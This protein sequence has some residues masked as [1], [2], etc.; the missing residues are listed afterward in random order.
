MAIVKMGFSDG[1]TEI[2]RLIVM[3]DHI[4]ISDAVMRRF[5]SR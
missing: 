5:G 4:G 3:M 1:T 2:G